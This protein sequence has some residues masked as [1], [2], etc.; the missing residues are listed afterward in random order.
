MDKPKMRRITIQVTEDQY[1]E[2]KHFVGFLNQSKPENEPERT[3]NQFIEMLAED[4]YWASRRPG[5]WEGANM[6][7]VLSSHGYDLY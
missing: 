7:T 2:I 5:S 1:E 4:L 3:I 6:R